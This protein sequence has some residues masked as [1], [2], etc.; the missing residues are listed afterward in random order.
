M[1]ELEFDRGESTAI[2][3]K[4]SP[5][6]VAAGYKERISE[7]GSGNTTDIFLIPS[8]RRTSLIEIF[9]QRTLAMSLQ[10]VAL[11]FFVIAC[12][13]FESAASRR[14]SSGIQPSKA[15]IKIVC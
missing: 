11:L 5:T 3:A 2:D 7:A 10:W 8:P 15:A 9:D 1:D 6:F 12:N 14:F 13:H 4:Q